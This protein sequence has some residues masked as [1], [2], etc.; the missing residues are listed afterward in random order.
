MALGA[1]DTSQRGEKQEDP[2]GKGSG[3]ALGHGVSVITVKPLCACALW[4]SSDFAHEFMG[5]STDSPA[6]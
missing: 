2:A 5:P 4:L 3:Q 1:R 6:E